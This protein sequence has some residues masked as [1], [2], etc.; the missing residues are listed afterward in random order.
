M[1]TNDLKASSP[2]PIEV[3]KHLECNLLHEK[4][5]MMTIERKIIWKCNICENESIEQKEIL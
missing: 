5:P 3:Q 1:N 2:I 4:N